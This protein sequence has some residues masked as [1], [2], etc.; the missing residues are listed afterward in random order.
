[1]T[2]PNPH[3]CNAYCTA[4]EHAVVHL[5]GQHITPK[6][7]DAEYLTGATDPLYGM[8]WVRIVRKPEG[9]LLAGPSAIGWMPHHDCYLL[10]GVVDPHNPPV[11][12]KEKA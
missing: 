10:F 8:R 12:R 6:G 11:I 2:H 1:M 3:T 9:D 4:E 7:L 5:V